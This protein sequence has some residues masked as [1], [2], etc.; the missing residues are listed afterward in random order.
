MFALWK[1]D[2]TPS[3]DIAQYSK[4]GFAKVLLRINPVTELMQAASLDS[5]LTTIVIFI[6]SLNLTASFGSNGLLNYNLNKNAGTQH[7]V[8]ERANE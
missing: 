7:L 6:N 3:Y 5:N 2:I 1:F 8:S 4:I